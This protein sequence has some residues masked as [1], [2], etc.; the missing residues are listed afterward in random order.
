M[1]EPKYRL[2][3]RHDGGGVPLRALYH[4]EAEAERARRQMQDDPRVTDIRLE[5]F[6]PIAR[7]D[8]DEQGV[9]QLAEEDE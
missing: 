4:S 1:A 9:W 7:W 6:S 8:R 3:W 5:R 2:I